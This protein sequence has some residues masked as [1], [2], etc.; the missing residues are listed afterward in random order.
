MG[1]DP[2]R[3]RDHL[4]A[5]RRHGSL[6]PV[7]LDDP[8]W[9][10]PWDGRPRPRCGHGPL[11][12]RVQ[13]LGND[14]ITYT[15]ANESAVSNVAIVSIAVNASPPAAVND[16]AT[17]EENLAVT[18]PVAANDTGALAVGTVAISA[19]P[20]HGTAVPNPVPGAVLYTPAVN[21]FGT[22]TFAYTIGNGLGTVSAPATVTVTVFRVPAIAVN[23]TAVT[24]GNT[25]VTINVLANDTGPINPATVAIVAL[26]LHGTVSVNTATGT[27]TYTPSVSFLGVDSFS[28]IVQDNLGVVSNVASVKVTVQ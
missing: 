6:L 16:V 3:Y 10:A 9:A 15:V 19:A 23:D 11:H 27:V 1:H 7:H 24:P 18:I 17:T 14:A 2:E 5:R 13:L 8:E 25:A 12:A 22:D 28:Y 4:R 21:F 26:P 20:L